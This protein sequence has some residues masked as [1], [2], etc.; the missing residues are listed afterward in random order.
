V[1]LARYNLTLEAYFTDPYPTYELMRKHDPVYQ[2]PGTNLWYVT[3]YNDPAAPSRDQRFSSARVDEFFFGV[4]D[5]L[6]EQAGA[7]HRFFSGW[8]VFIDPPQHTRLRGLMVRAFSPRTSPHSS[9][10]FMRPWIGL[11]TGVAPLD[12]ASFEGWSHD[13][14]RVPAWMG[15]TNE[16]VTVAYQAVAGF[17]RLELQTDQLPWLQ[18]LAARG[19]PACRSRWA[20]PRGV[21][22]GRLSSIRACG[23]RRRACGSGWSW[24]RPSCPGATAGAAPGRASPVRS[25]RTRA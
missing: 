20:E 18:S 3:R 8:L 23:R 6:A 2:L 7:V 11:S 19:C 13:V 4:S 16:N 22:H 5:D 15:D 14:F 21:S 25:H 17:P 24:L 12:N 10:S 9:H 1:G